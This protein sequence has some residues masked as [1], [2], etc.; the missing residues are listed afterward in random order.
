MA[1]TKSMERL[2]VTKIY[3]PCCCICFENPSNE[4]LVTKCGHLYC[5]PCFEAWYFALA[6]N[7]VHLEKC[8]LCQTNIRKPYERKFDLRL[9]VRRLQA[10]TRI[11]RSR[12]NRI[13]NLY[14]RLK[15]N[16]CCWCTSGHGSEKIMRNSRVHR[17]KCAVHKIN[18]SKSKSRIHFVFSLFTKTT[19][20]HCVDGS[21]FTSSTV[22]FPLAWVCPRWLTGVCRLLLWSV[23]DI[24]LWQNRLLRWPSLSFGRILSATSRDP[25]GDSENGNDKFR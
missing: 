20:F 18:N 8:P 13:R 5:K 7:C 23:V 25:I 17:Q 19:S 3:S 14:R 6:L 15:N 16:K 12:C 24:V 9:E 10:Q 22:N 11:T 1:L 21:M 4:L 2:K